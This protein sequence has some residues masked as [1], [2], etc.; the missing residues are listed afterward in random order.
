MSIPHVNAVIL[1]YNSHAATLQAVRD[2]SAA[3][4]VQMNV[5]VV[6]NAS[7]AEDRSVLQQSLAPDQLLMLPKNLGYAGG[8]NA[9]VHF[10]LARAPDTPVMLV[11]P[12]ARVGPDVPHALARTLAA[13]ASVGAVGP[14]ILYREQPR[15]I[16]AGGAIDERGRISLVPEVIRD[17]PYDVDWIEG[18]AMLLNPDAFRSVNGF[19]EQYFLYYEEIDLCVRLRKAGWHVR[20]DPA[21]TVHHPKEQTGAQP[22]VYY[23]MSRNGYRFRSQH[24]NVP[25]IFI[26]L[27]LARTSI[28]STAHAV[29]CTLLPQRWHQMRERWRDASLLW[30][31]AWLGTRDHLNGRYGPMRA[32]TRRPT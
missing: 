29:A 31:G 15:R 13:D 5:L 8:M 3:R 20:L 14:V 28:R 9:G 19:D 16:G 25:D 7:A 4:G 12:D 22:H 6:D 2:L 21:V 11:T 17:T 32:P 27:D 26:G 30:R 18:C 10:W 1:N 24:F 23:Y